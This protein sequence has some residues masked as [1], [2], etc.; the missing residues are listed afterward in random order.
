VAQGV[1]MVD[2]GSVRHAAI[3]GDGVGFGGGWLRVGD[4]KV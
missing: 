1:E 3:L 4:C 2:R